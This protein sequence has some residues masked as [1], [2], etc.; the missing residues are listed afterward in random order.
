VKIPPELRERDQWVVWRY[1]ERDGKPTKVPYRAANSCQRASTTD[2]A[3]WAG[4]EQAVAVEDADGIGFVFSEEDPYTGIDLDDCIDERGEV[5]AAAAMIVAELASYTERSPSG[6]GLHIIV[7]AELHSDRNKTS[8]TPWGG[9]FEVYNGGRFFTITGDGDGEIAPRQLDRLIARMFP[10]PAT[11]AGMN[12]AG[13]SDVD[14]RDL[15]DLARGARNGADFDRLYR[16]EHGHR[17]QSEADLALC[18]ALAFWTG[19]D[20]DRIDRLFRGSALMR[21]KW[22]SPR[23]G[24]TYGRETINT[25]LAGRTEFYTPPRQTERQADG[26][27]NAPSSVPRSVPKPI[28]TDLGN[29]QRFA[30]E[31]GHRLRHVRER[32]AWLTWT[33]SRWARDATGDAERAAKQTAR[34]LLT[35]AAKIEDEDKRKQAAQWALTSQSDPRIRAMLALATTELEIALADEQLDH[36]PW[37]LTCPNGTLDL[38]T[39]TLGS[40]D[41][42]D[43]ITLATDIAY[44]PGADC[45]RWR[46]FLSEVFAGDN[47]LVEFMR[48]YVGYCLTGDTR[49]E[50]LTVFHGAGCNGKSTF[51]RVQKRLAGNHAVT[52]SFDTFMRARADRAPRNDLARLH[53]AR[54]VTASESGE[55]RRLDEAIVK[56][57]TGRDPIAARFLYGEHFEFTPQFKLVLVTNHRPKVDGTD[58]A[59][60]R[61][62]RLVPFEQSFEGRE[63]RELDDRLAAE[64][65]GILA[66]AVQGCL[67]WQRDGLG[68]P[69]AVTKATREYRQ[70]EDLLGG[71]LDERCRL[72]GEIEPSRLRDAFEDYCR[73]IG[74]KPIAASVLGKQLARRG[75]SRHKRSGQY[76]GVSLR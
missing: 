57:I 15:L 68:Q 19:P 46:R 25:A 9:D 6:R 18:G 10:P 26:G 4:F 38:R 60:W 27:V 54:L 34:R 24:S 14:D 49:E 45:P 3:T 8:R 64:L 48:K 21:D 75:I 76:R 63:D 61:R 33:G 22:D 29:A 72:E 32:R 70:D 17:S 65:P 56:E 11:A 74:E 43:L 39:G 62:L 41:L 44:V 67:D 52:A 71:F 47:E 31:H 13:A 69:A 42:A 28:R 23:H 2:P 20:P 16:G 66:W 7:R 50:V 1:E 5:H 30:A 55:G 73:A 37:L 35:D 12:G 59:L 40:H 53:R 36:D 51:M 58:D